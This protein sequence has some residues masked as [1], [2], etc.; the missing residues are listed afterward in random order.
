ML[1]KDVS[2]F[3][4]WLEK[5]FGGHIQ[6]QFILMFELFPTENIGRHVATFRQSLGGGGSRRRSSL[7]PGFTGG[8]TGRPLFQGDAVDMQR[9]DRYVTC[10]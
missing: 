9:G 2:F 1:H 5:L 10:S 6:R 4:A 8:V 3:L 7:V